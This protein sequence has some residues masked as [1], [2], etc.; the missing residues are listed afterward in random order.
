[1]RPLMS[2]AATAAK[3]PP[4]IMVLGVGSFAQ[5]LTQVLKDDGAAVCT[6]LT[7]NYGHFPPRGVPQPG[8]V[9]RGA[10]HRGGSADVH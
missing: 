10:R 4:A 8:A 6:Y 3:R 1:M 9:A 2:Q 7:R 5:S